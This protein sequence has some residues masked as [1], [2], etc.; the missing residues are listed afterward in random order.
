[1]SRLL[2]ADDHPIVLSGLASLL[3]EAEHEIVARCHDGSEVMA[4]IET[5]RPEI[6]VL[7]IQMP[8]RTGLDILKE[9][10]GRATCDTRVII[11]T[12]SL[13][14]GQLAEAI[15]LDADG[16]VLKDAVADRIV[17]CVDAVAAGGQW[18][19]NDALKQGLSELARRE[20]AAIGRQPLSARERDVARLAA[21]GVRNRDIAVTLGLAESTVKMHLTSIFEKLKVGTRAQL[22]AMA[23]ELDIG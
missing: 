17:K 2:I 9:L 18:I 16:L 7:D 4:A 23:K 13:D 3:E 5:T 12:A 19:D 6:A 22:A 8:G 15:Q 10:R 11:L 1:M 14:S 20:T 21:T